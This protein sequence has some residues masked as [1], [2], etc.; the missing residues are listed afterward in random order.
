MEKFE[1][2]KSEWAGQSSAIIPEEGVQTIIEKMKKIKGKQRS[3]NIILAMT[4]IVLIGFF[5]YISAY[6]FR[7]VMIGL[8]LMIGALVVRIVLELLSINTINKLDASEDAINFKIRLEEYYKGRIKV[9]YILT[10]I[11]ILLYCIGFIMLLPS[12]KSTLSSGFYTYIWVSSIVLLLVLGLLIIK[13]VKKELRE[14][15]QLK[16]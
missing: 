12:F 2:L 7:T 4:C 14:L 13:Q 11:L 10:P 3:T 6:Q 8:L 5:V 16:S 15:R 9:H 1:E